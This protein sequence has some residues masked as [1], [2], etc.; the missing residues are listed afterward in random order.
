MEQEAGPG[1]QRILLGKLVEKKTEEVKELID[2]RGW[3]QGGL[4]LDVQ[5]CRGDTFVDD[6]QKRAAM[7]SKV[8]C[9]KQESVLILDDLWKHFPLEKVGILVRMK[10]CKLILTTRSLDNKLEKP[11]SPDV[12][13]IAQSIEREC[14]G[15]PLG[16]ITIA[17]SKRGADDICECRNA[18][19]ELQ[20]SQIRE[21][22]HN[23]DREEV[24][25]YLIDEGIIKGESRQAKFDE[26]HT[27]LNTLVKVF[28]YHSYVKAK[29]TFLQH[30]TMAVYV[31]GNY[32]D[33]IMA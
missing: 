16:I 14:A 8:F 17:A 13:E 22:D 3:F 23:I 25:E 27:L 32:M 26:G 31:C 11:L 5:Q 12:M 7:L 6:L 21:E 28:L 20:E 18:L 29:F 19:R 10:R 15:S 2:Q 30:T 33:V 9:E 24:I 4:L 1:L